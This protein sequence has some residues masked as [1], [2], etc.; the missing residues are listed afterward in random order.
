MPAPSTDL[1]KTWCRIDGAE[2]DSLLPTL[3]ASATSVASNETGVDYM[4][5]AMPES[6]QIWVAANVSYWIN[7][8]DAAGTKANPSPFI[9]GLLDPYRVYGVV[10]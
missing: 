4:T 6:V 1:V 10:V 9:S 2:F 7:N 8:P 5:D 3:I